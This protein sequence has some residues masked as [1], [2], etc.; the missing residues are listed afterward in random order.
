MKVLKSFKIINNEKNSKG[1]KIKMTKLADS[2][3]IYIFDDLTKHHT[4]TFWDFATFIQK[5]EFLNDWELKRVQNNNI[6]NVV[7][8]K[9]G[10]EFYTWQ[11]IYENC[12]KVSWFCLNNMGNICKISEK[13]GRLFTTHSFTYSTM[14]WKKIH[15]P[16]FFRAVCISSLGA[17]FMASIFWQFS[18][19]TVTCW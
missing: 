15:L 11:F 3:P 19:R 8:R 9:S 16:C 6:K 17:I 4:N 10:C 7:S 5:L 14:K 2:L 13:D 18:P 1:G 12:E